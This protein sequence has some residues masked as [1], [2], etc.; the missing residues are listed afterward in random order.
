MKIFKLFLP[1]LL[2]LLLSG[3]LST[4]LVKPNE[5][6]FEEEDSY[7]LFALR[8][9][10]LKEYSASSSIFQKLYEKSDKKEYL[11][12]SLQNDLASRE[13]QKVI[14]RVDKILDG[15]EKDF[16]LTRLKIVA[17]IQLQKLDEAREV[18]IK[19]VS[20]SNEVDDY[21]LISDIYIKQKKYD[22]A[23]KYLE[24]AYIK[25]YNEKILD[26]M[27]IVL[28]VNLQRKKDA[29]AQLETHLM[30][31]G[32]SK[33]VCNRLIGFYSNDNDIDGLLSTYLKLY[34]LEKNDLVAKKIVQIYGYK[35][36]YLKLMD[37]L[38]ESGS[39]DKTL[40]DIYIS[41][42]NYK[43][44]YPLANKLY[45]KIGEVNY[46]GQSAIFEY[47]SSDDKSNKEMLH[48]VVQTLKN[49]IEMENEP[50]YLNYL[51]YLMI[52]HS[53]D[54][55]QGMKYIKKALKINPTSAYYLDSLAW[56]YYKL[57]DCKKA[58]E[59]MQKILKLK[60]GD[61]SEV[62]LHAKSIAKCLKNKKGKN[63]K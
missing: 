61:E 23:I 2:I 39:D 13:N 60:G 36:D 33:V 7:I 30:I 40:L 54:I 5:K 53:L 27:S 34:T 24:S 16:I 57:G 49:V 38:Q 18:A 25:N 9:E 62:I 35:R 44:A 8:A 10:Q 21:I 43:K 50:L 56:G 32:A 58:D 37:F 3:C 52:D 48:G 55:K 12:R 17:L 45:K 28:Y 14:D 26:K 47:E 15:E 4:K 1:S 20:Q 63:K 41:F 51:G 59:M 11:Y 22:T 46:L 6:A 31:H 19:L 29:I 42:Q